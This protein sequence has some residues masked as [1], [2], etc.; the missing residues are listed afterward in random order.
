M[1]E[2]SLKAFVFRL[3]KRLEDHPVRLFVNSSVS[4]AR[5]MGVGLHLPENSDIAGARA[6]LGPDALIGAS[7]HSVSA[8]EKAES[9]GASFVMF[10]PVFKPISKSAGAEPTGVDALAGVSESVRIPVV[11]IGGI[12]PGNAKAC[13]SAGAQAVAAIGTLLA[14]PDAQSNLVDFMRALGRL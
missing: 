12:T 14:T 2:A 3:K 4:V 6:A 10:G 13:M 5:D 8:A 11:A 9:A 7:C 1:P